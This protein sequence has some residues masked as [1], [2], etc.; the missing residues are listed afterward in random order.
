MLNNIEITLLTSEEYTKYKHIIPLIQDDWWWLNE[1]VPDFEPIVCCVCYDGTLCG[2]F[3]DSQY[4]VRPVLKMNIPNH[5]SLHAGH[6]IQ[7]GSKMFTI[8]V[9]NDSELIALCDEFIAIRKFDSNSNEWETSEL[10]QWL[11]TEGLKL[12]F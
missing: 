1:S 4:G 7:L 3:C 9:W 12:I 10:K 11:K 8:L 6:K 5:K 2:C